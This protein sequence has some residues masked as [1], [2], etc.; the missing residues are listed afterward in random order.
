MLT[1]WII[2]LAKSSFIWGIVPLPDTYLL[3]CSFNEAISFYSLGSVLE[4]TF[5]FE[6]KLFNTFTLGNCTLSRLG[7]V[8]WLRF[9][10][11]KLVL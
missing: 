7:L 4:S 3:I 8:G 9:V 5:T 10:L 11:G 1:F 6:I 2:D